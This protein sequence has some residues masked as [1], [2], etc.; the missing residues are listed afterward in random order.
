LGFDPKLLVDPRPLSENKKI[1]HLTTRERD[2]KGRGS[3]TKEENYG[4]YRN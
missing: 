1:R 2:I 3:H 4:W